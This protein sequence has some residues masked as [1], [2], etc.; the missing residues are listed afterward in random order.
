M[1]ALNFSNSP[2]HSGDSLKNPSTW[3]FFPVCL[4][5]IVCIKIHLSSA[6][7]RPLDYGGHV[8]MSGQPLQGLARQSHFK[9]LSSISI[10]Q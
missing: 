7:K 6:F 1:M 4:V 5:K 10:G 8:T 2:R 3:G 9:W